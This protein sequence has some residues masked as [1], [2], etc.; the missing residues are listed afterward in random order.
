MKITGW[1][2]REMPSSK[3]SNSFFGVQLADS[4]TRDAYNLAMQQIPDLLSSGRLISNVNK[5]WPKATDFTEEERNKMFWSKA[6]WTKYLNENKIVKGGRGRTRAAEGINVQMLYVVNRDGEPVNGHVASDM[7]ECARN[8]WNGLLE[9]HQAPKKWHSNAST[10]TKA[11]FRLE[12]QNQYKILRLCENGWKCDQ[13]AIDFYSSWR[14]ARKSKGEFD[15][16][17][18]K[19]NSQAIHISDDED[20]EDGDKP[21]K[22]KAVES[23]PASPVKKQKPNLKKNPTASN[24]KGKVRCDL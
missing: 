11:Q 9:R 12:L 18:D 17:T 6:A 3:H 24:N 23:R 10:E 16:T 5:E 14:S 8:F 15:Q 20:G 21:Q 22:R 1:R 4:L 19:E 13:I 7:R 2:V